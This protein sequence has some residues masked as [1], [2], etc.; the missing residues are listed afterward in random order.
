MA[1]ITISNTGG[2]WNATGTWVG[3]VVP[4]ATD[5]VAATATSGNLTVTANAQIV[6]VNFTNYVNTFTVNSGI[7]LT[8]NGNLTFVSGMTVS[9][10]GILSFNPTNN[11]PILNSATLTSGGKTW[12]G[13]LTFATGASKIITFGDAWTVAGNLNFSPASS[14]V[15][16]TF[17]SNSVTVRG[18]ITV[19]ISNRVFTT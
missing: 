19:S 12:T 16:T 10:T 6:T 11:S 8:I 5:D 13:S 7:T 18:N 3:G 4:A 1:T 9:G 15:G 14:G 17:N 2:N